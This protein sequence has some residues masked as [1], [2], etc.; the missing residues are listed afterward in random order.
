MSRT[1]STLVM[2]CSP[3]PLRTYWFE[4]K[5]G[6]VE[7]SECESIQ[8]GFCLLLESPG[9]GQDLARDRQ[10]SNS[11]GVKHADVTIAK[12]TRRL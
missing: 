5:R 12:H 1:R 8:P 3:L 9:V 11:D 4:D 6:L 7:V 10:M 2:E